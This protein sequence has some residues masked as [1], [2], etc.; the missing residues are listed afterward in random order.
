MIVSLSPDDLVYDF[1]GNRKKPKLEDFPALEGVTFGP[2]DVIIYKYQDKEEDAT[3]IL[4]GSCAEIVKSTTR[5]KVETRP[6]PK[7]LD[8]AVDYLYS[9]IDD[10]DIDKIKSIFEDEFV[11]RNHFFA[12]MK[13]R[14][15]WD[16]WGGSV[17]SEYFN[18]LGIFH[19]DDM[20][21]IIHKSL[22][23]K[24]V[25]KDRDLEGQI[26]YYKEFWASKL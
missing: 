19:P 26:K 3:I 13:L 6:I 2:L 8:D 10:K 18:K 23:R 9:Q 21:G 4:K 20:S 11:G 16:L 15:N 22:Y 24:I 1:K 17:L 12:G 7:T 14:N 5:L 25:G